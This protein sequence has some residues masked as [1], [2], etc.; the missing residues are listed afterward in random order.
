M[1]NHSRFKAM[2]VDPTHLQLDDGSLEKIEGY[3][4]NMVE[5]ANVIVIGGF[6]VVD[7]NGPFSYDCIDTHEDKWSFT[8]IDWALF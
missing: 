6:L 3:N 5:K 7:D 8:P 4:E 1:I 2:F